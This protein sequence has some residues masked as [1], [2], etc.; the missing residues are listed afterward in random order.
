[1]GTSV[2]MLRITDLMMAEMISKENKD[3][4]APLSILAMS[5]SLALSPIAGVVLDRYGQGS[6]RDV[7]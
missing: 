5:I 7:T 3:S 1:M 6:D 2:Y 4:S